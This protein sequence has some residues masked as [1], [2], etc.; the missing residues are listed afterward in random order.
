MR[1]RRTRLREK[2]CCSFFFLL[3]TGARCSNQAE[4][5]YMRRGFSSFFPIFSVSFFI[6]FSVLLC[7]AVL[8]LSY[9]Q[10]AYQKKISTLPG[11]R[12]YVRH[13][14]ERM[15]RPSCFFP[16]HGG[17]TLGTIKSPLCN[18]NHKQL[19]NQGPLSASR[20]LMYFFHS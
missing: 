2:L 20:N 8:S 4:K 1:G 10:Q 7:R 12:T 9:I 6:V 14:N 15:W 3:V 19:F 13:V 16:K 11:V 18:Y 17:G 5:Y